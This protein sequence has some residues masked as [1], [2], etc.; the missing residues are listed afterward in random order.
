MLQKDL[1][2]AML[3]M[4]RGAESSYGLS[5]ED[6][7]EAAAEKGGFRTRG[8]LEIWGYARTALTIAT[9]HLKCGWS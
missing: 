9:R 1:M 5:K 2:A 7:A 8:R 4:N 3:E 6:K